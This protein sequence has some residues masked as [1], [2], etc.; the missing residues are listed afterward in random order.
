MFRLFRKKCRKCII[1]HDNNRNF[2][3]KGDE[4]GM[5]YEPWIFKYCPECGRKIKVDLDKAKKDAEK[6]I[7]NLE[8]MWSGE[9][10]NID[11]DG[12]KYGESLEIE[13]GEEE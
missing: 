7:K 4:L 11:I 1:G 5:L 3:Y 6:D 13:I 12:K 10:D 8:K 9:A 2:I